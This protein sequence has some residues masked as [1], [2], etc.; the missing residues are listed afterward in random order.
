MDGFSVSNFAFPKG[1]CGGCGL[2]HTTKDKITKEIAIQAMKEKT[3]T[4]APYID[5]MTVFNCKLWMIP[6]LECPF[7]PDDL[8]RTYHLGIHNMIL[9]R[10]AP[11]IRS[12]ALIP[13]N[14]TSD[15]LRW[16]QQ[17]TSLRRLHCDH[18][19]E[20]DTSHLVILIQFLTKL[21]RRE[22]MFGMRG[23]VLE[24]FVLPT[25]CHQDTVDRSQKMRLM[26]AVGDVV[27]LDAHRWADFPEICE[28]LPDEIF[29][30][31]KC[32][33]YGMGFRQGQGGRFLQRCRALQ[34]LKFDTPDRN[35]FAWAEKEKEKSIVIGDLVQLKTLEISVPRSIESALLKSIFHA[36]SHSLKDLTYGIRNFHHWT[37]VDHHAEPSTG[38]PSIADEPFR[39]DSSIRMHRMKKICITQATS[40]VEIGPGAFQECPVLETLSL[41]GEVT[42]GYGARGFDVFRL[43]SLSCLSLGNGVAK[44]FRL[45]SIRHSRLLEHLTLKDERPLKTDSSD[46]DLLELNMAAWTWTMPHLKTIQLSGRSALAFKFE[47]VRLCPS[48]EALEIDVMTPATLRPNMKD[49]AKGP[50]GEWLRTCQLNFFKQ[51]VNEECFRKILETYCGR[52]V[53]LKLTTH[54]LD[55]P[56][57]WDGLELGLVLRAAKALDSLETLTMFLGR[58]D[59]IPVM[60]WYELVEGKTCE[61]TGKVTWPPSV[62]LKKLCIV[63]SDGIYHRSYRQTDRDSMD[64]DA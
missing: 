53:Q 15:F 59:I 5:F 20:L 3:R 28:L 44:Y 2:V 54:Y 64:I 13:F 51:E 29:S 48:L 32:F 42:C 31:L 9:R 38:I 45:E 62:K 19:R 4:M 30:R 23:S 24:E 21:P 56:A 57:Q 58:R 33:E 26:R 41:S 35:V 25:L 50:C 47:W 55:S 7:Y 10:L 37:E 14:L 8:Y 27:S 61:E 60:T 40:A 16:A 43:P 12:M 49:I 46:L 6:I 11:K 18:D 36:F 39:I 22:T 34:A 63:N 1:S 52:V 17:M